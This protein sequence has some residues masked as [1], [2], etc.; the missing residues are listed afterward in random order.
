MKKP[1]RS[2]LVARLPGLGTAPPLLLQGH[3][4]V[5][6]AS[7]YPWTYPPFEGRMA[8]VISGAGAGA[9]WN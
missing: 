6:P 1:G 3:A 4:D 7:D 2:N 9:L 8:A 5:V